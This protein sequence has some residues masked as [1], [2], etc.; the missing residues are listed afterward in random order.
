MKAYK[1]IAAALA[2][3]VFCSMAYPACAAVPGMLSDEEL[4]ADTGR[5]ISAIKEHLES[6]GDDAD[7]LAA[8]GVF[9]VLGGEKMNSGSWDSFAESVR[10]G[11]PASIDAAYDSSGAY[12]I[13]HIDYDGNNIVCVRD[14]TRDHHYLGAAYVVRTYRYILGFGNDG[15][16]IVIDGL[17]PSGSEGGGSW[18]AAALSASRIGSMSGIYSAIEEDYEGNAPEV[19]FDSLPVSSAYGEEIFAETREGFE[20]DEDFEED[21]DFE[22]E[23]DFEDW[24]EETWDEDF[25]ED[26][27]ED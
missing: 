9:V 16:A 3:A 23:D 2:A 22:D 6:L 4:T 13:D 27:W 1:I 5:D 21:G 17:D 18:A 14:N 10:N 15:E 7:S 26:E 20:A 24:D 11:E 19:L 8:A 25:S 12:V